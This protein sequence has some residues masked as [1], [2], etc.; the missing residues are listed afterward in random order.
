[1]QT[2]FSSLLDFT[3]FTFFLE[4]Y[5]TSLFSLM[6]FLELMKKEGIMKWLKKLVYIGTL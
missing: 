4:L 2:S 5:L 3:V 1:L 6:S